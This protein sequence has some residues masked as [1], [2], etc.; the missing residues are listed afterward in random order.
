MEKDTFGGQIKTMNARC[1]LQE[2]LKSQL[3]EG[4]IIEKYMP[5]GN[6]RTSRRQKSKKVR[7]R[8]ALERF[9]KKESSR[10]P[11][12]AGRL[13]NTYKMSY[14]DRS[15]S[16][17]YLA[18]SRSLS[19][20]NKSQRKEYHSPSY[21][22]KADHKGKKKARPWTAG[23]ERRL[24]GNPPNLDQEMAGQ[25]HEATETAF[26]NDSEEETVQQKI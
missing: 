7:P 24:I 9:I 22:A 23:D 26:V 20:S 4:D 3:M 18:K 13:S 16:N 1:Q 5:N 14:N 25:F 15:G 10:R 2:E 6:P 8:S 17:K 19:A 21:S 11:K 12:T